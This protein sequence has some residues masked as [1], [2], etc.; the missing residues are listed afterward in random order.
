MQTFR[1]AAVLF[2]L[3]GVL[4][5]STRSVERQWRLWAQERGQDPEE[6]LEMAHGRRTIEV[7]R[8]L[9]PHLD[10]EAEVRRVEK[11]EAEDTDG[12]EVMPGAAALLAAIPESRWAVV[13]S[14][15]TH[16]ATSRLRHAK[17]PIP[18]VLVS[19]DEVREGKPHPEPYLLGARL[20]GF[21]PGECLVIEDAP[22]GIEAAH[23]A[24][25]KA[26]GLT[27]TFSASDLKADL[28]VRDLRHVEVG[29]HNGML[30]LRQC[31]DKR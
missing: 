30:E 6:I 26:I 28:V 3:D 22:A 11:R 16:L 2:D 1:C 10:I 23:A 31:V 21:P 5:D 27:S 4:V 7:I 14:G 29:S 17:L 9:A 25:M 15:T 13:T 8:W 20:L 24:G 18:K 19:A 12:V